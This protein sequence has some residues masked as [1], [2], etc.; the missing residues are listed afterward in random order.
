MKKCACD[1][2][3]VDL[4]SRIGGVMTDRVLEV[5]RATVDRNDG[6]AMDNAN[7]REKMIAEISHSLGIFNDNGCPAEEIGD[8]AD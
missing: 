2:P 3:V 7:D 5:I 1:L 4:V 8:T 6:L